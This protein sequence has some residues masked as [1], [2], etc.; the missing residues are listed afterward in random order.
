MQMQKS[1]FCNIKND[2]SESS[3]RQNTSYS[4]NTQMAE[5]KKSRSKVQTIITC[6]CYSL[7]FES[8]FGNP[9]SWWRWIKWR[10]LNPQRK[11]MIR[12]MRKETT[13]RQTDYFLWQLVNTQTIN[14]TVLRS[15]QLLSWTP[16]FMI[17]NSSSLRIIHLR[18]HDDQT[19]TVNNWNLNQIVIH[20]AIHKNNL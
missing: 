13:L 20:F 15:V 6:S 8:M 9:I 16:N 5:M 12:R 17:I 2:K 1:S 10:R 19:Y 3:D 7:T 18:Q 11:V 14:K 4:S